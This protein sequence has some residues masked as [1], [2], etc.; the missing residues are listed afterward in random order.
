MKFTTNPEAYQK[1]RI[2]LGSAFSNIEPQRRAGRPLR[3]DRHRDRQD[4]VDVMTPQPL[5]GGAL[6]TAGNLA[7]FGEGNGWFDARRREGRKELCGATTSA[8]A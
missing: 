3:R 1:G 8:R 6:A 2:R 4:R 7:F 5:I